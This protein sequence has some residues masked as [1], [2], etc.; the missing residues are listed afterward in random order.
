MADDSA[1]RVILANLEDEEMLCCDSP[2]LSDELSHGLERESPPTI[3]SPEIAQQMA[4]VLGFLADPNR[5]RLLSILVAEERCVGDLAELLGMNESAVSHQLR[6]LRALRLVTARKQG[7]HVFYRLHD[8]HVLGLYQAVV[9]N[10]VEHL[11]EDL[12]KSSS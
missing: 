9:E 7:R 8:H 6:T 3:L 11:A 1:T 12:D 2:H 4:E 5:L 10:L